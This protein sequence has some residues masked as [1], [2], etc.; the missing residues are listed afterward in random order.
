M[1]IAAGTPEVGPSI[2]VVCVDSVG[3]VVIVPLD[4]F[5]IDQ[6]RVG[7]NGAGAG[8]ATFFGFG[9]SPFRPT[10]LPLVDARLI[11]K[12]AKRRNTRSTTQTFLSNKH[13]WKYHYLKGSAV[14]ARV[15]TRTM[16]VTHSPSVSCLMRPVGYVRNV[17]RMSSSQGMRAT[18]LGVRHESSVESMPRGLRHGR[19]DIAFRCD[20]VWQSRGSSTSQNGLYEGL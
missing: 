10:R 3:V 9:A 19:R 2:K 13:K 5:R 15:N 1:A 17:M 4:G 16:E 7:T 14:S 12:T 11:C 8:A 20:C 6:F 18:R